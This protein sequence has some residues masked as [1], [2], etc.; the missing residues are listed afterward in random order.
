M[1]KFA[2]E[3]ASRRGWRHI[4]EIGLREVVFEDIACHNEQTD[5][6]KISTKFTLILYTIDLQLF[7]SRHKE[8]TKKGERRHPYPEGYHIEQQPLDTHLREL[9]LKGIRAAQSVSF[10]HSALCHPGIGHLLLDLCYRSCHFF[11]VFRSFVTTMAAVVN[12][13]PARVPQR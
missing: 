10:A 13:I 9:A 2:V 7:E 8:P 3:K 12:T 1:V 4:G 6:Q 11:I 5:F